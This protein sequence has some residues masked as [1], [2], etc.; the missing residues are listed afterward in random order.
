LKAIPT[1]SVI[2]VAT[3]LPL[4]ANL[5]QFMNKEAM[6]R[7]NLTA[8][9]KNNNSKGEIKD[10]ISNENVWSICN[11]QVPKFKPLCFKSKKRI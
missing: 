5:I 2:F 8:V 1:G 4:Q 11:K 7:K 6:I 9:I 10:E 3:Q